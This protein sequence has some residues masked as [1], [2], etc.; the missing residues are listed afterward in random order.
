MP[1]SKPI[2][3]DPIYGAVRC[4]NVKICSKEGF[5]DTIDIRIPVQA[6]R[7]SDITRDQIFIEESAG[8]IIVIPGPHELESVSFFHDSVPADIAEWIGRGFND[9]QPFTVRSNKSTLLT[10]C[11]VSSVIAMVVQQT[12]GT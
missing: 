11:P 1:I 12:V 8:T 6:L 5:S 9:S 10:I 4:I 3:I 7:V 2:R